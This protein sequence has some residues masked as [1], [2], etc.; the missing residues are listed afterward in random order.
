MELKLAKW[1]DQALELGKKYK[2]SVE[3]KKPFVGAYEGVFE[4]KLAFAIGSK[5]TYINP[6]DVELIQEDDLNIDVI[7][8]QTK[9]ELIKRAQKE[10]MKEYMRRYREEH[11][12]KIREWNRERLRRYRKQH[13]EKVREY[14]ERYWLKKALEWG[15]DKD[16]VN[17]KP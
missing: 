2:V 15:L 14:Q 3:G 8:E 12:D 6:N 11:K 10:Y 5:K 13:P 1:M 16:V 9:K 17:E 4:D 7:D